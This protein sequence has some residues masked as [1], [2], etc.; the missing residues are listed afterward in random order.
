MSEPSA[1]DLLREEVRQLSAQG[2]QL[3]TII[4]V[5]LP[6]EICPRRRKNQA[7][8]ESGSL[9]SRTRPYSRRSRARTH[10]SGV[11]MESRS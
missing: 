4:P 6:A 7:T 1:Y 5:E 10:R 9:S 2:I 11:P 3:Q 8:G